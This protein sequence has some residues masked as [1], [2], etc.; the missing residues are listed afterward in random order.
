MQWSYCS[1]VLSHRFIICF[2]FIK[3][4][5]S[6]VYHSDGCRE[7]RRASVQ[8][9]AVASEGPSSPWGAGPVQVRGCGAQRV[10]LLLTVHPHGCHQLPQ[11]HVHLLSPLYTAAPPRSLRHQLVSQQIESEWGF[12]G[13]YLISGILLLAKYQ[14]SGKNFNVTEHFLVGLCH[15]LMG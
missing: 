8:V 11:T 14:K 6:L 5:F 13:F 3:M 9:Q 7:W 10:T 15:T 2:F 4:I 1:F 12:S